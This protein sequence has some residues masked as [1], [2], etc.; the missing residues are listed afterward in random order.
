MTFLYILLRRG[1]TGESRRQRG[2]KVER[3]KW[4]FKDLFLFSLRRCLELK[5]NKKKKKMVPPTRCIFLF[6]F[7]LTFRVS[8]R[9]QKNRV[10]ERTAPKQEKKRREKVIPSNPSTMDR[11]T[12]R[13]SEQPPLKRGSLW[14]HFGKKNK[15]KESAK[16]IRIS[17]FDAFPSM[18]RWGSF[19]FR[20]EEKNNPF[21][22]LFLRKSVKKGGNY[23][24]FSPIATSI[25][26]FLTFVERLFWCSS[27]CVCLCLCV[28]MV[29]GLAWSPGRK[30]LYFCFSTSLPVVIVCTSQKQP[31]IHR[32]T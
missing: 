23:I 12:Q 6:L 1:D 18:V 25:P 19:S 4:S 11:G 10:M 30:L 15:F 2:Q 21:S 28:R 3:K 5:A 20:G 7:S 24:F 32:S 27:L 16:I 31:L 26:P 9:E 17:F 14:R 8:H 22:L 13:N 29:W